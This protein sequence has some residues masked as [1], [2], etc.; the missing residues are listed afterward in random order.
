MIQAETAAR[1]GKIAAMVSSLRK[2]DT[3]S[4][5][6][7]FLE[8]QITYNYPTPPSLGWYDTLEKIAGVHRSRTNACRNLHALLDRTTG[9]QVPVQMDVV[10]IPIRRV[11]PIRI[12]N[13]WW[14]Q[15]PVRN[16]LRFFFHEHAGFL[17]A[18][19]RLNDASSWRKTFQK[20]WDLY[21]QNDSGHPVFSK[22]WDLSLCLP[23]YVHGDEGRGLAR[24]PW[25]CIAWQP[26]ISHEGLESCNDSS[27]P[28]LSTFFPV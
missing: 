24:K 15:L 23:I 28:D 1:T 19:H 11:R 5:N 13:A 4:Q 8:I 14:P 16:W 27:Y 2:K 10:K 22:D 26:V 12:L 7:T 18:G 25:M 6:M 21:R 17:L 20:F 9:C 3:G